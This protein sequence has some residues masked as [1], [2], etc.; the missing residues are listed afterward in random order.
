MPFLVKFPYDGRTLYIGR[1]HGG[2]GESPD[3]AYRFKEQHQAE[4]AAKGLKGTLWTQY[5][6][7]VV[8]PVR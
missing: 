7:P 5:G 2:P 8:V 4:E 3:T 6:E 1:S